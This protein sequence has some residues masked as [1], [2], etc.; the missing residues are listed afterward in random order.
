[1]SWILAEPQW[2]ITSP[3]AVAKMTIQAESVHQVFQVSEDACMSSESQAVAMPN[4]ETQHGA[5]F[6]QDAVLICTL[7]PK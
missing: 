4:P 2:Q 3:I 6:P 5:P 7:H 1:M